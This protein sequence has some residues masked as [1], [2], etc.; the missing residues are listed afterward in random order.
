MVRSTD[1]HYREFGIP[2]AEA[3]ERLAL[4]CADRNV[5]ELL[6]EWR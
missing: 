2:Q 6:R 4:T 5:A 3:L 1:D